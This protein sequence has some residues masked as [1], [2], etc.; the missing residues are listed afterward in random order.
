MAGLGTNSAPLEYQGILYSFDEY[1][2]VYANDATNGN[3]LWLY[4]PKEFFHGSNS[5]ELANDFG[6]TRG[7]AMGDGMIFAPEPQGTMVALNAQTGAQVWAND[8]LGYYD[9]PCLAANPDPKAC[10]NP[11]QGAQKGMFSMPPTYANGKIF[12]A[13]SGGDSG[14]SSIAFALD[15]KT[16]RV[17]WHFNL[18]PAGKKEPGYDTWAH[19][20]PW[21]GGGAVWAVSSAD[22]TLGLVY[23]SVGNPIPYSGYLRGPGKEYFTDGEL[24]LH[25]DTGKE[26]W[27]FQDVHHDLWD[28]DQTQNSVLFDMTVNGKTRQAIAFGNK[29]LLVYIL[30]RATGQPIIPVT[31]TPVPQYGPQNSYA[32][33]PIP[34]TDPVAPLTLPDAH[35]FDG[36]QGP[37]NKGFLFRN[38]IPY[39][40]FAIGDTTGWSV[41]TASI[42]GG[43][44]ATRPPSY[45]P[46]TGYLYFEGNLNWGAFEELPTDQIPAVDLS[47][48]F[49]NG[50]S[51][52]NKSTPITTVPAIANSIGS[53]LTAIDPST[54][55]AVWRI[56][57][58]FA[59]QTT[60][61]PYESG[62]TTTDGGVL[63]TGLAKSPV[64]F[65]AKTGA[66]LWTGAALSAIPTG[67][68]ITYTVNG[69]QYVAYQAGF[70][71]S[72]NGV[73]QARATTPT[74]A[75]YVY[76]LS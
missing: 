19:P 59:N 48:R 34:A 53:Y 72:F 41:H 73:T 71:A 56:P 7:L 38:T 60:P 10:G 29:N 4:E 65:D 54:G 15:A 3:L 9:G 46:Q 55:K 57:Q 25:M 1:G 36:M 35:A 58:I 45:D 6:V 32:T 47:Q 17:L 13:S 62:M 39:N 61:T 33:Q 18:I 52:H 31:E 50:P 43:L 75:V 21:N 42:T 64:A 12:M 27:F 67:A 11:V 76:S 63:F 70:G 68:P 14:F 20:I 2:R 26:A 49:I 37:D 5:S 51:P 23:F 8:V 66:Q 16:G 40:V 28:Y 69:K 74:S 24:A 22:P 30:D 44:D